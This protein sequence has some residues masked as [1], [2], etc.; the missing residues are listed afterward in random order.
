MDVKVVLVNI[1]EPIPEGE[2]YGYIVKTSDKHYYTR[3]QRIPCEIE[4]DVA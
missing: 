3:L 4:G 2:G 1:S